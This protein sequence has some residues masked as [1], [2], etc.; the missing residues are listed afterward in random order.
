[1]FSLAVLC[2]AVPQLV[3][4][5]FTTW[6]HYYTD[7]LILPIINGPSEGVSGLEPAR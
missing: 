5:F 2:C 1:M 3:P 7:E 4:F 6:E